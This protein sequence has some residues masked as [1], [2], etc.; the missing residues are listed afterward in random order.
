MDYVVAGFGI[1]AILALIGFALWE[2]FG[3]V[4]EPGSSWLGRAAIG[5]MLGALV[6]WAVTGVSLI[7]HVDD[8]T[9]SHLVL[10]TTLVT[11]V[12]IAGGSFWYWRAD[13]ALAA[14]RPRPARAASRQAAAAPA[15]IGDV[16]LTEWDS[17]PERDAGKGNGAEDRA[18]TEAPPV[19]FEPEV[20]VEA[21]AVEAAAADSAATGEPKSPDSVD[22]PAIDAASGDSPVDQDAASEQPLP[23]NVRPF[24]SPVAPPA[25]EVAAPAEAVAVAPTGDSAENGDV[26]RPGPIVE[27]D[28]AIVAMAVDEPDSVAG[29][30]AAAQQPVASEM[31]DAPVGF[32]SSVLADIDGTLAD[33]NGAYRS[34][35]LSDLGSDQLE[36]VGLAKWRSDAALVDDDGEHADQ[37]AARRFRRK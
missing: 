12:A 8:S 10:L 3:T 37:P 7:S 36:G 11:L 30:S 31:V 16:E 27:Q 28:D 9:G 26:D 29:E 1:G 5:L 13:R 6:I 15:V 20:A 18:G 22:L 32:E 35:L 33:E 21:V 17:W 34:P 23:A 25:P 24:R 14:S 4:E 2:L 19:A